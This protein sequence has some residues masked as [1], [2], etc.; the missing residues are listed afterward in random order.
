MIDWYQED[1]NPDSVFKLYYEITSDNELNLFI[2]EEVD[3]EVINETKFIYE[4]I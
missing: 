2:T 4:I 3:D 1:T